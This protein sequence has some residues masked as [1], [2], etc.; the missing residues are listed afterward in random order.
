MNCF[1]CPRCNSSQGRATASSM[2]EHG[3]SMGP[4]WDQHRTRHGMERRGGEHGMAAWRTQTPLTQSSTK[5]PLSSTKRIV[6]ISLY[7]IID[8]KSVSERRNSRG[9]LRCLLLASGARAGVRPGGFL[10]ARLKRRLI[11]DSG[12]R[13]RRDVVAWGGQ[14]SRFQTSLSNT[15]CAVVWESCRAKCTLDMARLLQVTGLRAVSQ[16]SF[17]G[18]TAVAEAWGSLSCG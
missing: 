11:W 1:K 7:V 17:R 5:P 14:G 12:S 6:R 2:G 8:V 10:A 13:K 15:L 9:W 16:W 4:A 18:Q 3:R